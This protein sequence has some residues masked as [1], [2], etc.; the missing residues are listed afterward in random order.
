[1]ELAL[2]EL[3]KMSDKLRRSVALAMYEAPDFG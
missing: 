2:L 1:M 3:G